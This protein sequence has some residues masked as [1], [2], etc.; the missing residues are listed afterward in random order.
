[1][2]AGIWV[3]KTGKYK[4]TAILMLALVVLVVAVMTVALHNAHMRTFIIFAFL[5]GFASVAYVPVALGL[6]V[7]LT[8]PM[9]A[10]TS[11]GSMIIV[12]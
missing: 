10:F 1:M 7:E 9:P 6:G 4:S 12:G 8:F 3:D 11:N 5:L 2:I